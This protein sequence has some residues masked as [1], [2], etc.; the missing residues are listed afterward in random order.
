MR[1]GQSLFTIAPTA[2]SPNLIHSTVSR[3]P[4][5]ILWPPLT[6]PHH[7]HLT[8]LIHN[9]HTPSIPHSGP[10]PVPE[11]RPEAAA[12][13]CLA[14]LGE[15]QVVTTARARVR[16]VTPATLAG[17]EAGGLA[18]TI[19]SSATTTFSGAGPLKHTCLYSSQPIVL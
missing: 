9:S 19:W 17:L 3:L 18:D 13:L 7:S 12:A 1:L 6:P 16:Q 14:C 5:H 8:P 10:T 4:P 11:L 15:A 2:Y